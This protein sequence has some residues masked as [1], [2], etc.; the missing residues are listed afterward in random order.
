MRPVGKQVRPG[1]FLVTVQFSLL[2]EAVNKPVDKW[3]EFA[4]LLLN[5]F[6]IKLKLGGLE[7]C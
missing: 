5:C 6:V 1:R 7:T 4:P 3:S 2:V